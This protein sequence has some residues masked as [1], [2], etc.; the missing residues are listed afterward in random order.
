MYY[1]IFPYIGFLL[2]SAGISFVLACFGSSKAGTSGQLL[3]SIMMLLCAFWSICNA[4]EL[5]GT[6]LSVKLFWADMQYIAYG[7]SPVCLTLLVFL[8]TG[9]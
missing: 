3:F 7:A 4:F 2:I 8:L 5:M 1:R 6:T 9:F